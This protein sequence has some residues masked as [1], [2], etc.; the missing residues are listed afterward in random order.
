[1]GTNHCGEYCQTAFK[2]RKSF[3][4]VLCLLDY[5]DR[6]VASFPHKIQ[7]GYYGGNR[8]V[9]IEGI[10]LEHFSA[11]PMTGISSSTKSCPRHPVFHYFFIR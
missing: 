9:F 7:S 5:A 8:S 10:T 6:L 4:D 1:M 2:Y 11:L 3:Q